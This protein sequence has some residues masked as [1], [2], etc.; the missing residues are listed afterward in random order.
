MKVIKF[1]IRIIQIVVNND[2]TIE[3]LF[4]HRTI[5]NVRETIEWFVLVNCEPTTWRVW[6]WL[7]RVARTR[8]KIRMSRRECWRDTRRSRGRRDDDPRS[9]SSSGGFGVVPFRQRAGNFSLLLAT[10][11]YVQYYVRP[12]L[13]EIE[14]KEKERKGSEGGKGCSRY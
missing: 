11:R 10:S 6:I 12:S 13:L 4:E 14:R 3:Q 7:R 9:F 8:K 2:F 5:F 1:Y